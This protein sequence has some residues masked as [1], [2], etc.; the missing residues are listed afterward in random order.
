MLPARVISDHSI[1]K[2]YQYLR[3]CYTT[4]RRNCKNKMLCHLKYIVIFVGGAFSLDMSIAHLSEK[5]GYYWLFHI[6][7]ALHPSERNYILR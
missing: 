7:T 5:Q 6:S 1:L 3:N 4:K 2:T